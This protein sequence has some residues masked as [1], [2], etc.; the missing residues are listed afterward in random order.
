MH[1]EGVWVENG[2]HRGGGQGGSRGTPLPGFDW[3]TRQ[4]QAGVTSGQAIQLSPADA[5]QVMIRMDT[6]SEKNMMWKQPKPNS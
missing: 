2:S 6:I 5:Q 4:L 1:G 3:L